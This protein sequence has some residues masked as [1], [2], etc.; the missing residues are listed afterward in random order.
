LCWY[1]FYFGCWVSDWYICY[2]APDA[3]EIEILEWFKQDSQSCLENLRES[4]KCWS[5]LNES[6]SLERI[7]GFSIA[8]TSAGVQSKYEF[9]CHWESNFEAHKHETYGK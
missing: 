9:P 1:S 4:H 8:F 3:V 2:I 7:L 6:Q 5:S